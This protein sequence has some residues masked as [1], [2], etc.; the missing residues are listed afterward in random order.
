MTQ[1]SRRRKALP[2]V[3]PQI[4]RRQRPFLEAVKEILE[5]GDG[6]RGDP[7]DR[8]LTVRDLVDA[9]LAKFRRGVGADGAG[10]V[11]PGEGDGAPNMAIPPTPT[12]FF[13]SDGFGYIVLS[14]NM[15]GDSYSNH[16]LTNIYR[17]ETDN[18]ANA[19]R[20]GRDAGA[21]Y[22]DH[23]RSVAEHAGYYYWITFTSSTGVEG[24]PNSTAGTYAEVL[25]DVGFLIENISG[26]INESVLAPA[27]KDRLNGFQETISELGDRYTLSV[28]QNGKVAGYTLYNTGEQSDFSILADRFS[29]AN[30]AGDERHPFIL[31]GGVSYL[32]TAMIRK[33]S[34]QSGQLGSVSSGLLTLP[35][36]TPI[37]TVAGK[38][39][40]NGIDTDNLGVATA[41]TFHGVA[42]SGNYNWQRQVGWQLHPNGSA[43]LGNGAI[44][45]GTAEFRSGSIGGGVTTGPDSLDTIRNRA[46]RGNEAR[47]RTDSW[48]RPGTTRINGN[49][50]FTG[51]AYVDTLQIKGQ[52]VTI[53]V[54]VHR[55][56]AGAFSP[57]NDVLSLYMDP[58]GAPY[59][60]I[61]FACGETSYSSYGRGQQTA[62][63]SLSM[64]LIYP[65]GTINGGVIGRDT[66]V[67]RIPP[68]NQSASVTAKA[69]GSGTIAVSARKAGWVKI[70][71]SGIGGNGRERRGGTVLSASII[72][73][74]TKR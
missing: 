3:D 58:Q 47:S 4:D 11:S 1:R 54:S 44:I 51:D 27:F 31:D 32:D 40:A 14:W 29:I 74:A 43:V 41:A 7:M 23:I 34:I 57:G 33:G 53:P 26:K 36:G 46:R 6:T 59:H 70:R 19:V 61:A 55:S 49:Q 69:Q 45:F 16:G 62:S 2:P 65:D 42:K 8:K 66:A 5:T 22:T 21:F 10:I 50:I 30:S 39:R 73:I 37:T 56:R 72:C 15:P 25:P 68:D 13:A 28:T 38:I 18:F 20:I 60:I 63:V 67:S 52:A 9:G 35:D 12:G 64:S 71:L 48:T 24:P 17:S